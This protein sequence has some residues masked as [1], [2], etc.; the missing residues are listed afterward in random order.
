MSVNV[1]GWWEVAQFV[2]L[3]GVLFLF[4]CTVAIIFAMVLDYWR[5]G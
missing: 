5:N 2:V 4:T 3:V 1:L